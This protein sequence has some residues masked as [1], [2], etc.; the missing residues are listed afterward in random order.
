MLQKRKLH[1][2]SRR[3]FLCRSVPLFAVIVLS[4]ATSQKFY[5]QGPGRDELDTSLE[6]TVTLNMSKAR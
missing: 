4:Q 2:M 5:C 3:A 1:C 6:K